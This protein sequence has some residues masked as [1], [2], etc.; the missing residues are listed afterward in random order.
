MRLDNQVMWKRTIIITITL[1]AAALFA[2]MCDPGGDEPASVSLPVVVDGDEIVACVND[3][4]WTVEV[5]TFRLAVRDLEFTI[6]GEVHAGLSGTIS[7]LLIPT[8]WAHPGHLAG[9]EV[10]GE[11]IGDFVLDLHADVEQ[12]LGRADLLVGEYHGF[13]LSFRAAQESDGLDS[14]DPLLGHTAVIAGH[15]TRGAD[16]VD[17]T[18]I[19]DV[20]DGAVMVGGTF[21][22]D[23]TE[24]TSSTLALR[25][26]TIDPYENDTLF[27]GLDFLEIDD[28]HDGVAF[29]VPG[30]E[31]HNV[32]AKTIVRHD[33]YSVISQP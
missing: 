2:G 21:N 22:L 17:F 5:S 10:T 25:I 31:A 15:A 33:H 30:D 16:T 6:E 8:V 14:N 3:E 4:G 24:S 9:G 29:I 20:E 13:N 11:L 26:H 32:L 7:E 1:L 19:L 12:S 23:V 18:T 27:D 28:D